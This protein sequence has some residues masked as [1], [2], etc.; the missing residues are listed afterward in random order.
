MRYWSANAV[1]LLLSAANVGGTTVHVESTQA[2]DA[3]CLPPSSQQ[4][5]CGASNYGPLTK[6]VGTLEASDCADFYRIRVCV[7]T[8][9]LA[10]TVVSGDPMSL[11]TSLG[12]MIKDDGGSGFQARLTIANPTVDMLYYVA[13]HRYR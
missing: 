5:L 3:G 13:I 12:V 9:F 2:I 1:L 10:D 8:P 7:D 6:I 11:S 4:T